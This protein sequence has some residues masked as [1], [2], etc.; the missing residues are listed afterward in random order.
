MQSQF[1]QNLRYSPVNWL[2]VDWGFNGVAFDNCGLPQPLPCP[3]PKPPRQAPCVALPVQ[4]AIDTY[5]WAKF[6]PEVLVGID[7]PDEDIAANYIREAAI[8]FSRR[9]RVLQR[10]VLIPLQPKTC[11]YPVEPY[12]GEQIEGVIGA[13][14]AEGP[15]CGCSAQCGG[16]LPDGVAF[17]MDIARNQLYLE[18]PGGGACCSNPKTLRLLVWASPTEDACAY[19][20]FLY[21]HWRRVIAQHARRNYALAVHFRDRELLRSLPTPAE[22]ERDVAMAKI[23]SMQ[24]NSWDKFAP[25]SG[26]WG[27][28]ARRPVTGMWA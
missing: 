25:G 9:A 13:A 26:L 3:E 14:Y 17:T 8:E 15:A 12:A 18:G 20:Q 21:S 4:E 7:N 19:D 10:Q 27:R 1:P 11:T 28:G 6:L 22:F 2:I 16:F 24:K 5:D 23:K